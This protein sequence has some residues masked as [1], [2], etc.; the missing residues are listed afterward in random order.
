MKSAVSF[1]RA[2]S[3]TLR[4][5]VLGAI[6]LTGSCFEVLQTIDAKKDGTIRMSVR[7]T[8]S[9]ALQ[10]GEETKT[11]APEA[12]DFVHDAKRIHNNVKA[13]DLSDEMTLRRQFDFS[14]ARTLLGEVSESDKGMFLPYP[15]G[16][17]QWVFLFRPSGNNKKKATTGDDAQTEQLA[18]AFLSTANYRIFF[19]GTGLPRSVVFTDMDGKRHH[20]RPTAFGD[21][22]L[23]D[24]PLMLVFQ[25]GILTTSS[26]GKIDFQR[27]D[28][29]VQYLK[30]TMPASDESTEESTEESNDEDTQESPDEP[31]DSPDSGSDE[32]KSDSDSMGPVKKPNQIGDRATSL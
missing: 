31:A 32:G 15:D 8:M 16:A 24:C 6:F 20:L 28:R 10:Q 19:R 9:K 4:L 17:K 25:G 23:I 27:T 13:Q 14:T 7:I 5:L 22:M 11:K 29:M 26:E 1:R 18:K 2:M 30:D 12:K 3:H 21:G